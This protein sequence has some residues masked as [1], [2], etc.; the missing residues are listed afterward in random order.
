MDITFGIPFLQKKKSKSDKRVIRT[1]IP[2]DSEDDSDV[3]I[4]TV[5]SQAYGTY[6]D[7]G[8][9][10]KN[11][12][13]QIDKYRE[14][15]IM[16][17]VETAIDE[18][19]NEAIVVE[20]DYPVTV[21]LDKLEDMQDKTKDKIRAEFQFILSLLDFK[22]YAHE[23]FKRWYVDGKTYYHI[24]TDETK[25]AE[26]VLELRWIDPRFLKKIV[27]VEKTENTKDSA[28]VKTMREFYIYDEKMGQDNFAV[29]QDTIQF[30]KHAIAFASSGL[31]DHKTKRT[32]SY[33]HKS[34]KPF[35]QL[36]MIEDA[37]IIYRVARSP[38]RRIFYVDIGNLSKQR[39]EEYLNKVM[40]RYKNKVVYNA[41][42]G[43]IVDDKHHLS[44]ME[45]FWLPRR[46]GGRGTEVTTLQGGA[47]LGEMDDVLYFQ[48]KL[49]K[50]L[51]V[52]MSRMDTEAGFTIGRSQEITRDELKF[53]KFIQRLRTRFSALFDQ[54]LKTQLILKN[55]IIEEDWKDLKENMFYDFASD[56]QFA[57]LKEAEILTERLTIL[58]EIADYQGRYVSAQW[59]R[60]NVLRQSEE[61]M[62]EID[63]QMK[64]EKAE[65]PPPEDEDGG[66]GGF[67]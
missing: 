18:I 50:S 56:S 40:N 60:E 20:D 53:T 29:S 17:D 44:M 1:P 47:S 11:T 39:G 15:S 48:K 2:K 36:R 43:E 33:L 57:E 10:F 32:L 38:E 12:K 54:L 67:R 34:I 22:Q 66:G 5:G 25:P 58:R 62:K 19:I 41:S 64:K 14:I 31:L 3:I 30:E 24:I 7:F 23:V 45:D 59:I 52:P 21:V 61:E 13:A 49:Y 35:N 26:G 9:K 46:E 6:V 16:A 55:I 65:N 8:A 42:S 63:E 51:G 27:K 4:N 28:E 37:V